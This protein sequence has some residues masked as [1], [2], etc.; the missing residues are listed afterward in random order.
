VKNTEKDVLRNLKRKQ[1][2]EKRK[3]KDIVKEEGN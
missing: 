3:Q 1:E 2:K